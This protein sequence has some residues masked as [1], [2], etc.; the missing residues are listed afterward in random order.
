MCRS[1][2]GGGGVRA[3]GVCRSRVRRGGGGVGFSGDHG[4]FED[5]LTG[6]GVLKLQ[7]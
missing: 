1:R 2:L 6:V 4:G 3:R 5:W 7:V